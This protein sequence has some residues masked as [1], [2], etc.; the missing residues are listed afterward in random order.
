M[1]AH[2]GL[3][4][5]VLVPS[6]AACSPQLPAP[7]SDR[8]A[9][10]ELGRAV[11][12]SHVACDADD[13]VA[14]PVLRGHLPDGRAVPYLPRLF[15]GRLSDYE[16]PRADNA[17]LSRALQE[18][19]VPLLFAADTSGPGEELAAAELLTPEQSYSLVLGSGE[20]TE[21]RVHDPGEEQLA[22]RSWPVDA[23]PTRFVVYCR[24]VEDGP[25]WAR[26][27]STIDAVAVP[28]RPECLAA[29]VAA[30]QLPV[31]FPDRV[32]GVWHQPTVLSGVVAEATELEPARCAP[33]SAP[34]V[35]GCATVL[36]DRVQ[37]HAPDEDGYWVLSGPLSFS[38]ALPPGGS[39]TIRGLL[40]NT[41]T[42]VNVRVW[43]RQGVELSASV[44][45]AT[46]VRQP[47]VIINEIFAN[48]LGPE[49]AQ[50]WVELF[51]DGDLPV[52]LGDWT[53]RDAAGS[54]AL[55]EFELLPGAYAL[56]VRE[57]YDASGNWD[58]VPEVHTPLLRIP[59]ISQSG[60]SNS[61]EPIS[62]WDAEGVLRS[63][64]PAL[65]SPNGR[66]VARRSPST[67]DN[68]PVGF[69]AHEPPGAS[70]GAANRVP[71]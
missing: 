48:P 25:F 37:L 44:S 22:R 21:L 11:E 4:A 51:N 12:L 39:V 40:P 43:L 49:P 5:R 27:P 45:L 58:P 46:S 29:R 68:D 62:L 1:R 66:S 13:C 23:A 17:T 67:A 52:P 38:G 6:V 32:D 54:R 15:R 65:R 71:P 55:P 42:L 16:A 26:L 59:E 18:R 64:F 2:F 53:L 63:S 36:D 28:A 57:D 35:V 50:E 9:S 70:P 60:L 7:P 47:H 61:G 30:G 8:E 3:V 24:D 31:W 69:V 33:P 14:E 41:E 34:F 20:I 10:P 56:I 19:Q